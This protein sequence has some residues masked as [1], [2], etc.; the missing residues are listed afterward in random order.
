M[1]MIV[2][3]DDNR[4]GTIHVFNLLNGERALTFLIKAIVYQ[5]DTFAILSE[6]TIDLGSFNFHSSAKGVLKI[7]NT[8]NRDLEYAIECTHCQCL[9][10][11]RVCEG[12]ECLVA[13]RRSG[14]SAN[15]LNSHEREHLE[16][17]V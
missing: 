6:P 15:G 7:Q 5:E 13:I 12:V 11:E 2:N 14:R 9:V 3:D 8:A 16:S 1:M 4:Q 17:S 10:E